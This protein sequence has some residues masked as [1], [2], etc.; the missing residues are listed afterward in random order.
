M[1]LSQRKEQFSLAY[2]RAV[3]AAAGF[4]FSQPEVDDDSI[5]LTLLC[6]GKARPRLDLQVKCTEA[7][8]L[9]TD[10]FSFPLK[11]KNYDDLRSTD[12]SQPRILV[13]VRIPT[14]ID[15]WMMFSD[16]TVCMK[17]CGYWVNIYGFPATVNT[18]TVNVNIARSNC[19]SS[20]ALREMMD[21]IREDGRP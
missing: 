13:V 2:I 20:A 3:A 14:N 19:F 15:E 11:R 17:R 9:E 4:N 16:N 1:N 5:D 6:R 12:I 8:E 18:S 21:R 7:E 10:S